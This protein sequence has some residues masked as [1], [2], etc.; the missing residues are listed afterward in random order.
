[1]EVFALRL[2]ELRLEKDLSIAALSKAVGI[3]A[4]SICRWE[5]N[6][7]DVKGSQLLILAKFFEVSVDYLL[8][9]DK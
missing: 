7:A 6:E 4:A 1:M 3:G 8:G 2:K 9:A 5:N